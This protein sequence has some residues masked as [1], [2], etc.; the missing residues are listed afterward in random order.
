MKKLFTLALLTLILS[1]FVLPTFAQEDV[2]PDVIAALPIPAV[3][4]GLMALNNRITE[5]VKLYLTANKLPFTPSEDV[6]R[7]LVLLASMVV[8]IVSAAVTPD[9]LSWLGEGFNVYAGIVVTGLAVSL[10]GGAVQLV[11]SVLQ[12]LRREPATVSTSNTSTI[13]V[14]PATDPATAKAV[15]NALG[16][17]VNKSA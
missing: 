2:P 16:Q 11:L 12:S 9:A 6:R 5:A 10:G 7:F 8:G 1:T 14:S 17:S 15:L 3:L 13:S 4:L